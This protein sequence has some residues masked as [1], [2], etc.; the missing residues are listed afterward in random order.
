LYSKNERLGKLKEKPNE[1]RVFFLQLQCFIS[2]LLC[3]PTR[4]SLCSFCGGSGVNYNYNTGFSFSLSL[5]R[6]FRPSL[7]EAQPFWRGVAPLSLIT[8]ADFLL[9]SIHLRPEF[10]KG[11]AALALNECAAQLKP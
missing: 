4:I 10:I 11:G 8:S 9:L 3:W 7:R 5:A 1:L 2:P 6:L